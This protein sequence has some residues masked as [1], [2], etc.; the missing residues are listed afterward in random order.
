MISLGD[1]VDGQN[2][3]RH[4]EQRRQDYSGKSGATI[5]KS[6]V[7]YGMLERSGTI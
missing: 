1:R 5:H 2:K 6:T 7:S 4:E 3:G